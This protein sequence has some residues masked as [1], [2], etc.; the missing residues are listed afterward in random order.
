VRASQEAGHPLYLN[1]SLVKPADQADSLQDHLERDLFNLRS[2]FE[3]IDSAAS[4]R[5]SRPLRGAPRLGDRISQ[6]LFPCRLCAAPADPGP[7]RRLSGAAAGPDHDGRVGRRRSRRC[8]AGCRHASANP[9]T[10]QGDA[11]SGLR[12][13]ADRLPDRPPDGA[14]REY[15]TGPS[16]ATPAECRCS[17]PMS[18]RSACS[19]TCVP[20]WWCTSA[21]AHARGWSASRRSS[22]GPNEIE[23][24]TEI[25]GCICAGRACEQGARD[26]AGELGR[27]VPR[28]HAD[29]G[30]LAHGIQRDVGDRLRLRAPRSRWSGRLG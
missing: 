27:A 2:T 5:A 15:A 17:T 9:A 1:N 18:P 25:I 3:N 8:D 26:N 24:R 10:A 11:G 23:Y 13:C 4:A 14:T 30:G 16:P 21:N 28:V 20:K 22:A 19:T 7:R 6:Q 29:E 12:G